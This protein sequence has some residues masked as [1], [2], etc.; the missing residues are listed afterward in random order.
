MNLTLLYNTVSV[1]H[2]AIIFRT[3]PSSAFQAR[4]TDTAK[5]H[6]TKEQTNT[7]KGSSHIIIFSTYRSSV[8]MWLIW[9]HTFSVL[10]RSRS[11]NTTPPPVQFLV[12]RVFAVSLCRVWDGFVLALD[13]ILPFQILVFL[14]RRVETLQGRSE[15]FCTAQAQRHWDKV[16]LCLSAALRGKLSVRVTHSLNKCELQL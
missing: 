4:K 2:L 5:G 10:K 1:F 12:L 8:T 3:P 9:A 11:Y 15:S 16:S 7:W 14:E 13:I 6:F